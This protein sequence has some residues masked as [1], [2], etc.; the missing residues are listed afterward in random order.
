[1]LA[2]QPNNLDTVLPSQRIMK[3]GLTSVCLYIS[4]GLYGCSKYCFLI[5]RSGV[6]RFLMC[7]FKYEFVPLI[8]KG[9]FCRPA[10]LRIFRLNLGDPSLR[11]PVYHWLSRTW[12]V[13]WLMCIGRG[14]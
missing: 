5:S 13:K 7:N 14:D 11:V 9:T 1:M 4:R 6:P 12:C 3:P 10:P 2:Q 8:G